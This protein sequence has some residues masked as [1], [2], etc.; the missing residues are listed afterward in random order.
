MPA[1]H[2]LGGISSP[3]DRSRLLQSLRTSPYGKA[4]DVTTAAVLH[5]GPVCYHTL[6][7]SAAAAAAAS[8][9]TSAVM[10]NSVHI[11][12]EQYRQPILSTRATAAHAAHHT[13]TFQT[14]Q[15][16][17]PS[18]MRLQLCTNG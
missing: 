13:H 17:R 8:A 11:L 10:E 7:L 14:G 6:L 5:Q 1:M 3:V 16:Y 18:K 15:R 4:S 9:A 2:L 12:P